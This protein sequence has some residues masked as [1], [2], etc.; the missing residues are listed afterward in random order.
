VLFDK[1]DREVDPE[2]KLTIQERAKREGTAGRDAKRW[3]A[4]G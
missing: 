2:G 3:A 4:H 1:F